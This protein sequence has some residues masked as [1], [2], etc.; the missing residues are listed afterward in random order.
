MIFVWAAESPASISRA[1][2]QGGAA[3]ALA[4]KQRKA[5]AA[6]SSAAAVLPVGR[7]FGRAFVWT[8]PF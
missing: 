8:A 5:A 4:A 1:A 6:Q 7:R 2:C 3:A